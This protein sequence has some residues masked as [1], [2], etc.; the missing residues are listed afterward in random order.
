MRRHLPP[1][2]VHQVVPRTTVYQ[3]HKSRVK[4]R[5]RACVRVSVRVCVCVCVSVRVCVCVSVRVCVCVCVCVCECVVGRAMQHS[6][7]CCLCT[8]RP[9]VCL[10]VQ[11]ACRRC[12][13][14]TLQLHQYVRAR[15]I[16]RTTNDR[17]W[18]CHPLSPHSSG[19]LARTASCASTTHAPPT[20]RRSPRQTCWCPS[21]TQVGVWAGRAPAVAAAGMQPSCRLLLRPVSK[22]RCCECSRGR[23]TDVAAHS[24]LTTHAHDTRA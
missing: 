14:H 9:R 19:L 17:R 11:G 7:C 13:T 16:T 5:V 15:P 18:K 21:C 22:P 8:V 24:H 6:S 10:R 23:H 2:Q 12:R 1:P 4:V 20:R 3:C